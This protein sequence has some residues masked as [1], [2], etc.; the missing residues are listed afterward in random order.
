MLTAKGLF[1]GVLTAGAPAP[2]TAPTAVG[3]S[4]VTE[5]TVT[6]LYAESLL[7]KERRDHIAGLLRVNFEITETKYLV[8]DSKDADVVVIEVSEGVDRAAV[9]E[10][11]DW[12]AFEYDPCPD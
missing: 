10:M 9:A 8:S 5:K 7:P 6:I 4:T 12:Y 1:F 3:S 2:S 11:V